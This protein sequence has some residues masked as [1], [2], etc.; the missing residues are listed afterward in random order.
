MA[1]TN[2]DTVSGQ[3]I[4]ESTGG[5]T[6]TY[7]ADELGSVVAT[8]Q[9]GAIV[10]QYRYS[11]YGQLLSKAG[12]GAD[13]RFG[14]IGEL[15]YRVTARKYAEVYVRERCYSSSAGVWTSLDP[16][17][18]QE[19]PYSYARRQPLTLAD[20]SG[21][22][23][24]RHLRT[25]TIPCGCGRTRARWAFGFEPATNSSG[26]L[27]QKITRTCSA[28]D[29]HGVDACGSCSRI[30][31]FEAWW[32]AKGIVQSYASG[33]WAPPGSAPYDF[34]DTWN[35]G[36]NG[37]CTHG[38]MSCRGELMFV[39]AASSKVPPSGFK[40]GDQG[41][42]ECAQSLPSS[43]HYPFRSQGGVGYVTPTWGCCKQKKSAQPLTCGANDPCGSCDP[44]P[45]IPCTQKYS[46]K[47]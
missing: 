29:C 24:I 1:V 28:N 25:L 39:R 35:I 23:P 13:P 15:G 40:P 3:L 18:L 33:S 11:P 6:T 27:I 41:G 21:L 42:V 31:Y 32:V 34:V 16:L 37:G 26:W 36:P 17:W 10:N 7:L 9:A 2:Y 45:C 30:T 8:A 47:N 46:P 44:G 14:W 38:T 43:L 12:T 22:K 20:P 19:G 5:V 4:G